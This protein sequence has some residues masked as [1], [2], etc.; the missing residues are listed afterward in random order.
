MS[1]RNPKERR[2]ENLDAAIARAVAAEPDEG[3][4]PPNR[5]FADAEGASDICTI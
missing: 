5:V 1:L 4:R 3:D 2:Q